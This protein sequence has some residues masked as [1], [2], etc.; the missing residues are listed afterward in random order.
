[1]SGPVGDAKVR[2]LWLCLL[3]TYNVE[4]KESLWKKERRKKEGGS[5]LEGHMKYRRQEKKKADTPIEKWAN[6]LNGAF[7]RREILSD[8]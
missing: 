6:D 8:L 7:H 3:G 4:G 2:T 1:M 5:I